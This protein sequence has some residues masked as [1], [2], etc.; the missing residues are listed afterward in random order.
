VDILFILKYIILG[1]IEGLTEFLPVSSTGH[2][3]IFNN[4]LSIEEDAFNRLFLV[5]CQLAAIL[6]VLVLYW[7]RIWKIIV[8]FFK[9][10]K[11][12]RRFVLAWIMGCVP[13]VVFALLFEDAIDALF[14][15]VPSVV[16][17]L[18]VGALLLIF[19]EKFVATRNIKNDASEMT[20][21]DSLVVG[22]AQCASLW[23]G[24]SRSASTIMGG[25]AAGYTTSAA[26]D[27]SF[28]LAIPIMFGASGYSLVK[29]FKGGAAGGR[30]QSSLYDGPKI[31]LRPGLC[32]F[33][34]GVLDCGQDFPGVFEEEAFEILLLLPPGLV[35]GTFNSYAGRNRLGGSFV[36]ILLISE[37]I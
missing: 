31:G 28:F 11:K 32:G 22:V 13:A 8:S 24:F 36:H 2:L 10:E 27:F 15:N 34:R 29:Y 19:G 1:V 25:W 35:A 37:L 6:A 18:A 5:V 23:P 16:L 30:G 20:V 9:W 33:F 26:A 3:I 14:F 4:L 21:K 17:A 12:G 7:P